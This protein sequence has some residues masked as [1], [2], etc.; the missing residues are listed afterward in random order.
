MRQGVSI[1][2]PST[3]YIEKT[4]RI[5]SNCVIGPFSVLLGKTRIGTNCVIHSH[6]VIENSV[7]KDGLTILPFSRIL[8]RVMNQA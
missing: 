5:G 4:V 2:D 1:L 8:N 7:V 3:T 6:V